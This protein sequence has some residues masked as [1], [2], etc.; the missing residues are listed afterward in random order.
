M[1]LTHV[2]KSEDI[3]E[4][5]DTTR[6]RTQAVRD[7]H[8][9]ATRGYGYVRDS[10]TRSARHTQRGNAGTPGA[11]QRATRV[12]KEQMGNGYGAVCV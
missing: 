12:R 4:S 9:H 6:Y 10:H 5:E 2:Y 8:T 7:T 1:Y 11:I 3:Q